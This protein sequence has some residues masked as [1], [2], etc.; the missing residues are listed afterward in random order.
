M[1]TSRE[2][3]LTEAPHRKRQKSK[4]PCATE[5]SG[6]QAGTDL[7]SGLLPQLSE[8]Q[9]M[10]VCGEGRSPFTAQ[11]PLKYQELSDYSLMPAGSS[12]T[13]LQVWLNHFKP[14]IRPLFP[15]QQQAVQ[16]LHELLQ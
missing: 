4:T 6:S 5:S 7:F 2:G 11:A 8:N 12:G 9:V 1:V 3:L 13:L 14:T 16:Y 10:P 15:S